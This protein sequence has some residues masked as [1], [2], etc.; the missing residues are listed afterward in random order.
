MPWSATKA[1]AH[2]LANIKSSN[3]DASVNNYLSYVLV[4]MM[5][6][7]GVGN[8]ISGFRRKTLGLDPVQPIQA[9][10]MV[11]R[12][13]IPYTYCWSVLTK[14]KNVCKLTNL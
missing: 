5:I 11:T 2:P 3:A 12:L 10:S 9:P 7:Q 1:F 4:E 8:V 13:K 14:P 6:W